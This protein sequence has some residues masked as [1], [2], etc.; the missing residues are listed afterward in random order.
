LD[1]TTAALPLSILLVGTGVVGL[2][3]GAIVATRGSSRLR[4]R[5]EQFVDRPGSRASQPQEAS[6]PALARFRQRFNSILAVLDSEEMRRRLLAANWSI[7]VSEYWFLRLG[8]AL[9]A[10]MLGLLIFRNILPAAGVG[11][12]AYL[13]PGVLLFRG[14]Q[15]RQRLFQTQLIDTLTLIRGAVASGY[16]FQQSLSVV[17]EELG[18]PSSDEFRQVRRE[19]E[20]GMPLGRALEN[21]AARL[22]SEDFNLVVMV[23]HTNIQIGGNLGTILD[24]V[25]ATIRERIAL[26]SEIRALTAYANFAGYLL[27]LLP[28]V[29]VVILAVLSPVYWGQLFEPG[30]TRVALIY[31]LCSM[32]VG[33]I[34]LRRIAK[35]K[36]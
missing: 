30:A 13:V 33:N 14:V 32:I 24:V 1:I 20:L 27:T 10:F 5:L 28:F 11:V 17:I 7:T 25:I 29:T 36:V 35:V 6:P 34:L 22:E 3:I 15:R 23:V 4:E 2:T 26:F 19:V 18:P 9:L 12:L 21:M 8:A 16:S 31:A